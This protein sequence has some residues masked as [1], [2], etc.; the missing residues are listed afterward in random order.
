M[1]Y[2]SFLSVL[3]HVCIFA[4]AVLG[5]PR[6][7]DPEPVEMGA[8]AVEIASLSELE[9]PPPARP[10]PA[11]PEPAAAEPPPPPPAAKAAPP[12]PPAPPSPEPEPALAIPEPRPVPPEAVP[13]PAP[14]P[15]PK[16]KPAPPPPPKAKPAP[17][18]PPKAVKTVAAKKPPKPRRKPRPPDRMRTVL[19]NLDRIAAPAPRPKTK[20]ARGEQRAA[21]PAKATLQERFRQAQ[22]R[23]GDETAVIAQLRLQLEP[24]WSVPAGAKDVAGIKVPIRIRLQ[25][26]GS[27]AGGPR[28]ENAV[29]LESDPVYRAV[30]ESALRA[31]RNPRCV[32]FKLPY[33][34]YDIW[35]D[36][37]FSFDPKEM[38]GE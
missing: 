4:L 36:V 1:G 27:L 5:L 38:L 20:P 26:D 8:V 28:V 2:G 24:C 18:P 29:R 30:A 15:K 7:F 6:L 16:A 3:L 22:A 32:P 13:A 34:Q 25:P 19:K 14:V 10:E 35:K 33:G 37:V 23:R 31:L 9:A 11:E 12:P 17:P 21:A